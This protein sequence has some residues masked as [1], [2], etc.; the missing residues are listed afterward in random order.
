MLDNPGDQNSRQGEAITLDLSAT[1]DESATLYFDA[2]GLPAGLAIDHDS[3]RISGSIS[4]SGVTTV[5]A[6]VSD[7][8]EVSTVSFDWNVEPD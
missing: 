3:G 5:T 1:D 8:P 7:G 6:S 2:T 4:M